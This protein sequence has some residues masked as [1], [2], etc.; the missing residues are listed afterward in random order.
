VTVTGKGNFTGSKQVTFK[1]KKVNAEEIRL[2]GANRYAT[3]QAIATAYKEALGLKQ[4]DMICVA[5]GTNYPDA[6][7][8]SFLAAMKKAP[9]LSVDKNYPDAANTQGALAYIQKNLKKGGTV[10]LLGGPG[11]V[12]EAVEKKLKSYGFLVKR[13]A[14]PNR[15]TSNLA[16]L[17]EA[18]VKAGSEFIVCT[19]A[20]FADALSASATGKPVLLVG[21]N[22][23]LAEQKEYLKAVKPGRFTII[24]D[25]TVVAAGIEND[26]KAFAKVSRLT[27][28]TTYE[29]SINVAR[30]YF[31][32]VQAHINIADGKNFPDALCGGPMAVLSG[33]P[34][35]LVD[36][37]AAVMDPVLAYVKAAGTYKV[38]VYG[39]TGSVSEALV[40]KV[41]SVY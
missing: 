19:G 25:Q 39:G 23:L 13:V 8:G 2:A 17:E 33:G 14:G 6:L 1:I 11:S 27:G 24:G 15:Y 4:F 40:K 9:I 5:D 30:K 31:P 32:G 10:Y 36:D 29:R 20:D 28:K 12:P 35:L 16:I 26:L 18:K 7:A 3:S 38:T 22:A 41:L 21:G 37:P 34:L